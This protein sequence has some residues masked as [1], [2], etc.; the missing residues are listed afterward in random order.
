VLDTGVSEVV[1]PDY[2]IS[3]SAIRINRGIAGVRKALIGKLV[4]LDVEIVCRSS[5]AC[6]P[7]GRRL[8]VGDDP[9]TVTAGGAKHVVIKHA[10]NKCLLT[11]HFTNRDHIRCAR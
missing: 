5:G 3:L 9:A 1:V 2:N 10:V 11:R 4:V 8:Y 7:R 6:G